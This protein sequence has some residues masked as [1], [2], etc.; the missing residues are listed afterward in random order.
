I[1]MGGG[2]YTWINSQKHPTLEKLDRVLMSFDWE[3]LFPLVSVRKLVR[4]VSDHNPLLL[5]SSP[6]KT[7]PLHNREF[8]FEL[9]WLKNEEFYLKAKSIW[10]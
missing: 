10:E 3:D 2:K 5:S 7:S 4:D 1:D 9:S 8:R 6:V